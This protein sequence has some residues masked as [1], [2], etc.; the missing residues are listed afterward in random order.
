MSENPEPPKARRSCRG[1]C[2]VVPALSLLT[3]LVPVAVWVLQHVP[4]EEAWVGAALVYAPAMQWVVVP[5]MGVVLALAARRW[6]LIVLN[7]ASAAFALS[8]V[9]GYQFNEAACDLIRERVPEACTAAGEIE[10]HF[11]EGPYT[12]EIRYLVGVSIQSSLEAGWEFVDS[13]TVR[14]TADDIC[15]LRV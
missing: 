10:P 8:V 3:A 2:C 4:G 13:R 11:F 6:R 1:S 15:E 5:L 9:A 12:Q 7:A 14:K